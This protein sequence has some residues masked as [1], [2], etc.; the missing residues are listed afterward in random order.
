M[1]GMNN[2]GRGLR[3]KS[4]HT[5]SVHTSLPDNVA[6]EIHGPHWFAYVGTKSRVFAFLIC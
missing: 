5:C 2:M 3:N 4:L 6:F 1:Y